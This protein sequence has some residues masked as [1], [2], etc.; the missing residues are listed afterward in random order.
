MLTPIEI[1]ILIEALDGYGAGV[2]NME[3]LKDIAGAREKLERM[4]LAAEVG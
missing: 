4:L 2:I 3:L 1:R